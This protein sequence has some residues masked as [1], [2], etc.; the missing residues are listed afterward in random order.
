MGLSNETRWTEPAH[1]KS[2]P[3]APLRVDRRIEDGP[4]LT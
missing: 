1:A 2:F 3:A 4:L